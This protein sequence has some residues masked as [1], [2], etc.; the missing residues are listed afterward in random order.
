MV[1][2]SLSIANWGG[3]DADRD[4]TGTSA[5]PAEPP[6]PRLVPMLADT[7]GHG[8]TSAKARGLQTSRSVGP[9]DCMDSV[10][11][12]LLEERNAATSGCRPTI[13]GDADES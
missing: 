5:H 10:R 3:R 1:E 7:P 6:P 13:E 12:K 11:R 9:S 8:G 2:A 4:Q